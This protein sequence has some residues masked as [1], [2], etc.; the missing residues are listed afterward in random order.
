MIQRPAAQSSPSEFTVVFQGPPQATHLTP[1]RPSFPASSLASLGSSGPHRFS[2]SSFHSRNL[3]FLTS[4]ISTLCSSV[5]SPNSVEGLTWFQLLSEEGTESD[6]T[7]ADNFTSSTMPCKWNNLGT[8]V[9]NV[10][11]IAGKAADLLNLA[12]YDACKL[13][14]ILWHERRI[15]LFVHWPFHYHRYVKLP[16]SMEYIKCF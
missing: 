16:D 3:S 5:W 4:N 11:S 14:V 13:E 15:H 7:N 6:P 12:I 1:L 9:A 2:S 10:N 8:L